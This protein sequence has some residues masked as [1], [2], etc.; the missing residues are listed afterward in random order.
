MRRPKFS[1]AALCTTDLYSVHCQEEIPCGKT[2]H[3]C[4]IEGGIVIPRVQLAWCFL[5]FHD[6]SV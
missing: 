3:K 4:L 6:L 2:V 1:V 5:A